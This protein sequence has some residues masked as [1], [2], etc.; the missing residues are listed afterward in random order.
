MTVWL[1]N[2]P[3]SAEDEAALTTRTRLP[4][5]YDGLPDLSHVTSPAQAMQM[6]RTLFPDEPPE[7]LSTRFEKF[8][9]LHTGLHEDDLIALPLPNTSRMALATVAGPYAYSVGTH[10]TDIHEIPV[11][12]ACEPLPLAKFRK[13]LPLFTRPGMT[14]VT[15]RDA[16]IA[17]RGKLPHSYNR[18]DKF[19]WLL[20]VF[21]GM[22]LLRMVMGMMESTKF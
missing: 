16:R 8:W 15:D 10:G 9:N 6:L 21:M 22:G 12:W 14:E 11:H 1:L 17:L 7:T 2:L 18:F 20:A 19:K 4:L 13:H 3:L 5:P